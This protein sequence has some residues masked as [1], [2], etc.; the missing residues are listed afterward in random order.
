LL[1]ATRRV[2]DRLPGRAEQRRLRA[3]DAAPGSVD[4]CLFRTASEE[5]AHIAGVLR[6]GHLDGTP[7]SRMA[8][9]VRSTAVVLGTLR[10]ALLTAGV[11]VAVRGEDLPLAE[12]PAVALLLE[13]V[14]LAIDPAGLDESTAERL[15]LGA[16][17]G[18]DVVYLQRLRR[19]LR[20]RDEQL[21]PVQLAPALL[22]PR[23]ARVLPEHVRWPV[24][25]V[26][27]A[28]AAGRESVAAKDTA[29]EVLWALW[30][31]TGLARKW[32]QQSAAGGGS[33][34]AADRDL[35]AVVALFAAVARFTDRLPHA[36]VREFVDHLAA[37]QIPG[38]GAARE[39]GGV[40]AVSVL[41][42]HASKGL[43]WELVCI[44]HAQEG[45]WPDLRRRGSLLGGE[46][47][48][49][50]LAG[51]DVP[52]GSPIAP[53]LAEERRLFYVAAT[54][55][56]RQL[57]V[58]AVS[59]DEE[60]PSRFLDELDPYDGDRPLTPQVRG[61][62][63]SGLV[64]ELR[65]TVCDPDAPLPR[66]TAAATEL[67]R[68]AQAGVRGADPADWWGLAQLSD[69]RPVAAPDRLVPVSPSRIDS[70]LRCE[71]RTLLQDVGARDGE[72]LSASLGTLVHEL[73]A[74][75]PDADLAE[76][77]R[78]LDERWHSL[79]FGARWFAANERRR[80]SRILARLVDWL[81]RSRAQYTLVDI[82]QAFA[83]EV[84]DALLTG[85]VDRLERDRDGRLVVVDLKTGKSK[86]R[87]DDLPAH[88]QL[89]AYQLAVQA[90]A[91]GAGEE[92]GGALL[93]QLAASGSD[94][95]QLQAPLAEADDPAWVNRAVEH[96]A[97]RMRG[98][99]FTARGNSY[100]GNCD[101]QKCC[102]VYS[103]QVTQ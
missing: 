34:A 31:A 82:E 98:S 85:R 46:L 29:E 11:P 65:A 80:A 103:G 41:T 4:V 101:L 27:G 44:A 93:V 86:V 97:T 56:R 79:D 26:C 53:R 100:C 62:H 95:E 7:W 54:R 45:S 73:A 28:L 69:D 2:A 68:L 42:A 96:V 35:D 32:A 43:E 48:V 40:D 58:T 77:E 33:G 64:A 23:G 16:V 36:S 67:A 10:R 66:R 74:S 84:G 57:V 60:Q 70:F 81:R 59:A 71:V 63:L 3:S 52:G 24:V 76:L 72:Q 25:R 19:V 9:L 12:Q 90:G 102:P 39:A 14:R 87:A 94:P 51:I 83:A 49:D 61:V 89:G 92:S 75:A 1:A 99:Q 8:V 91:F 20:Q 5:A 6:R 30:E 50:V 78:M 37:Q 18:G 21:G 47:L 13:L 38:D 55:A 15:L 88:P 22:D 17:G